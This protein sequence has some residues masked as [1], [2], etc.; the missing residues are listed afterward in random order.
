MLSMKTNP[1]EIEKDVACSR[2]GAQKMGKRKSR[3][4][5]HAKIKHID[6]LGEKDGGPYDQE[7]QAADFPL[8]GPHALNYFRVFTVR[9]I[10][11]PEIVFSLYRIEFYL[12]GNRSGIT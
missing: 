9:P 6:C 10:L 3:P 7:K 2:Q 12:K 1:L 4:R 11:E 8:P 5:G